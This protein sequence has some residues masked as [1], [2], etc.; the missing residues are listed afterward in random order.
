MEIIP[1]V[2]G[3]IIYSSSTP[4]RSRT[5]TAAWSPTSPL[6][7]H[8]RPIDPLSTTNSPPL[9]NQ[10]AG[11]TPRLYAKL[12][13]LLWRSCVPENLIQL[14]IGLDDVGVSV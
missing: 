1:P 12:L 3:M 7:A 8:R 5:L 6:S 4:P 2:E 14:V 13:W 9:K 11:L 10:V